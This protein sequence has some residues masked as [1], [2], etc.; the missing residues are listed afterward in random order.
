MMWPGKPSGE[1]ETTLD[2]RVKSDTTDRLSRG[3]LAQDRRRDLTL[4]IRRALHRNHYEL[5]LRGEIL[6]NG[7]SCRAEAYGAKALSNAMDLLRQE[8]EDEI[9]K[10]RPADAEDAHPRNRPFFAE[11]DFS[12]CHW[13]PCRDMLPSLAEK[14]RDT[15]NL[16]FGRRQ[17]MAAD[18]AE[19]RDTL[20]RALNREGCDGR[21]LRIE[22]RPDDFRAPW[23]VLCVPPPGEETEPGKNWFLGYR[24][25]IE[26]RGGPDNLDV[27]IRLAPHER[28]LVAAVVDPALDDQ[29]PIHP[30]TRT[31]ASSFGP[32]ENVVKR[33]S[34]RLTLYDTPGKVKQLLTDGADGV[35]LL[36]LACHC[37]YDDKHG[38][39]LFLNWNRGDEARLGQREAANWGACASA[40]KLALLNTCRG[41]LRTRRKGPGFVD[42]LKQIGW[43]SALAAPETEVPIRFLGEYGSRFLDDFLA[44]GERAGMDVGT[45][46]Q[47]LARYFLD[48][49]DNPLA[50]LYCV[51]RNLDTHLC[52]EDP[53]PM[54]LGKHNCGMAA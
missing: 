33:A 6:P 7:N 20:C 18:M 16:L 11:V 50:L 2:T 49:M 43:F 51:H 54:T 13:K 31:R 25:Q 30:R 27:Q 38:P 10:P 47:R 46:V 35:H 9:H 26:V 52:R 53:C 37:A 45:I 39:M 12:D 22:V 15:F 21:G 4:T 3:H 42:E 41:G 32:V 36:Y 23:P 14:G 5:E 8:W 17:C 1:R 24:H 28:P 40:P 44:D 19:L 34:A 48:E 29:A